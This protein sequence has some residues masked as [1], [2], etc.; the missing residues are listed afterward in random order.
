MAW[1]LTWIFMVKSYSGCTRL[2][3]TIRTL[4]GLAWSL[5]T[6][7]VVPVLVTRGVGPIDAIKDSTRILKRTWGEQIAGTIGIGFFFGIITVVYSL[8]AI[9]VF[10][11][12]A[13]A[14]TPLIFLL[15]L[16]GLIVLGYI[17]LALISSAL[18]G[19]YSAALYRFATTG[20]AGMFDRN[21]LTGAFS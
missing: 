2:S 10:I 16:A 14:K 3:T 12:L 19:I 1:A 9:P 21:L 11:I 20:E 17:V 7:L 6:Y 13:I 5:A 15:I 18:K 4:G 8:I